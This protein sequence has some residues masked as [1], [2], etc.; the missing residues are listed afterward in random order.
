MFFY[1][2]KPL[3]FIRTTLWGWAVDIS[4]HSISVDGGR[5]DCARAATQRCLPQSSVSWLGDVHTATPP[6]GQ[7]FL[8]VTFKQ[9]FWIFI[10]L[11]LLEMLHFKTQHYDITGKSVGI[12]F[13]LPLDIRKVC[14]IIL[15]RQCITWKKKTNKVC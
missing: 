13:T 8:T 4:K 3:C 15:N 12:F 2:N 1:N 9:W 7:W 14:T 10:C 6:L 5:R 11:P